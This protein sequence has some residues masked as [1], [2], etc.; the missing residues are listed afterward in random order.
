M[1]DEI[2]VLGWMC[3]DEEVADRPPDSP[4]ISLS[5]TDGR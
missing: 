1:V 3:S 5:V 4:M 2:V